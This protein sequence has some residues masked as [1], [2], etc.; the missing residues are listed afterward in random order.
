MDAKHRRS[1]GHR[2]ARNRDDLRL[3]SL[4]LRVRCA[5]R[6]DPDR[7]RLAGIDPDRFVLGRCCPDRHRVAVRWAAARCARSSSCLPDR[8]TR[9]WTAARCRLLRHNPACLPHRIGGWPRRPWIA[10]VLPRHHDDRRAAQPGVAGAC[11]R[12][13]DDLGRPRF[14]DLPSGDG[15]ARRWRR[16][17]N[18]RA[19]A[20]WL[21]DVCVPARRRR[22]PAAR[23]RTADVE[24][25]TT[26]AFRRG[27][28]ACARRAAGV[29]RR[30]WLWWCRHVDVARLPGAD[31]DGARPP[32]REPQPRSPAFAASLSWVDGCP[33]VGC[34]I[35]WG[36]IER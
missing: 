29:R 36:W 26:V 7:H 23:G 14:G 16:V 8:R 34:W 32:G 13:A 18:D 12:R 15:G 24:R 27:R 10:R 22:A 2:G 33:S 9:R 5:A 25:A 28:R 20:R 1:S 11:H 31:D 21:G 6:P 17:A 3:R 4:V 35:V 30:R 19:M